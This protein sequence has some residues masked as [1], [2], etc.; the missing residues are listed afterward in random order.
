MKRALIILVMSFTAAGSASPA[1]KHQ[2]DNCHVFSDKSPGVV[3]KA[4][5]SALCVGCHSGR[6]LSG[7]HIVDV[8]PSMKID[9]L[10]LSNG[11]MTC[12]TCHDP[13]EKSGYPKFLRVKPTD[14]CLKCHHFK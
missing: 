9:E 14:L 10:P 3:L 13:H 1:E 7:E 5:L 12:V 6:T 4:P 2:C 11:K 8:V